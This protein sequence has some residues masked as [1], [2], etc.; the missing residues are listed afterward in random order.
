MIKQVRLP[1]THNEKVSTAS[2]NKQVADGLKQLN[3]AMNKGLVIVSEQQ[4]ETTGGDQVMYILHKGT[5]RTES[6]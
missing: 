4:Y 5:E 2:F 1:L 6:S 3:D